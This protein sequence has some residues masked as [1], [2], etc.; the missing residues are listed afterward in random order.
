MSD[1]VVIIT[2][3]AN[4]IGLA[5]AR[6]FLADGYNVVLADSNEAAG[7]RRCRFGH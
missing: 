7:T 6:R 2:G 4:G 1:R 5:C 3:A